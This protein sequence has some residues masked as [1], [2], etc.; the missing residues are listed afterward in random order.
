LPVAYTVTSIKLSLRLV[1]YTV[2]SIK[3]CEK[4]KE[5]DMEW[6]MVLTLFF[7]NSRL[8]LDIKNHEISVRWKTRMKKQSKFG[9]EEDTFLY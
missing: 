7:S 6:D 9:E 2:T 3:F 5:T 4:D 8:K 1:T